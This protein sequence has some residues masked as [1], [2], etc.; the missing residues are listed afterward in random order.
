MPRPFIE[1]MNSSDIERRFSTKDTLQI[2]RESDP[3]EV[4]ERFKALQPYLVRI[5]KREQDLLYMHYVMKKT[6]VELGCIFNRTQAAISYRIK[7]AVT[8][9]QFLMDIPEVDVED[10]RRDLAPIFEEHD[11]DV[12]V[13]MFVHTCQTQV[14]ADLRKKLG[15][16]YDKTINQSYVRHKFRKNIKTLKIQSEYDVVYIKYHDL[17]SKICGNT[18][19]L[20]EVKLSRWDNGTYLA[21]EL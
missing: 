10:I 15:P 8:R 20:R 13:G 6:Q 14:A 3:E 9:L 11:M 18:N 2:L 12:M 21:D 7:K 17:F 16:E 5:P 1:P 19:I 4:A